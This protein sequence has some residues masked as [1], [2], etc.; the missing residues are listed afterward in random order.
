MDAAAIT[1][2]L[3]WLPIGTAVVLWVVPLSRYWTGGVALLVSLLEAALWI[4]QVARFDFGKSGLQFD[5]KA[6]WFKD[7]HVSYHV[8]FYGFSLWLAGLT[9]IVMAACIGYGFWTGPEGARADYGFVLVP[10]GGDR[11]G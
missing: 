3:I 11:A 8:G 6:Q 4:E 5:T 2:W 7:L 10:T 1:N 9:V